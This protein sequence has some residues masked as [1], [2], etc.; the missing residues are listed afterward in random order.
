MAIHVEHGNAPRTAAPA[1][2]RAPLGVPAAA[3]ARTEMLVHPQFLP[4]ADRFFSMYRH[5]HNGGGALVA[6][7][8]TVSPTWCGRVLGEPGLASVPV[9]HGDRAQAFARAG[10]VGDST[11]GAGTV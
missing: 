3:Q 9:G 10:C 6:Y 7:E 4:L 2:V 1:P 8:E 5:P 11:Q